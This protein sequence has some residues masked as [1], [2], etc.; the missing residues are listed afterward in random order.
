MWQWKHLVEHGVEVA[1]NV[2]DSVVV[3]HIFARSR[4]YVGSPSLIAID[5]DR[6]LVSHDIF[7]P[8]ST[9]NVSEVF[10]SN[11]RGTSWMHVSEIEGQWWSTLFMHDDAIYL[12]G[13][14]REWGYTVIR[15]SDD[16]GRTWTTPD[17]PERGLLLAGARYHCAP[18]PIIHYR[19]RLWR[20][21]EDAGPEWRDFRAFMMSASDESNLLRADSW[22]SSNRLRQDKRLLDGHLDEWAE[23][24]AVVDPDG[25]V[26]D[27]L[28]T[29]T[30]GLPEEIA[31][32]VHT[33]DD[34]LKARFDPESDFIHMPGGGKKFTI[35]W[36]P[37]SGRYWALTNY[38]PD[39]TRTA[40]GIKARNSL[41][42]VSSPDL[43]QWRVD[44]VVL[45]HPDD[46]LHAFQY[47]DWIFDGD[48]IV[49]ASRTAADDEEGGAHNYHDANYLTHHR[50]SSFRSV[51]GE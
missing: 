50:L 42:L 45:H 14:S 37:V 4:C 39:P 29:F 32:I 24:N 35:R 5:R 31:A 17:S 7:G 16:D 30:T 25:H 10:L 28:R 3:D 36:D 21:M 51:G 27:V 8:G 23:G 15:R 2:T 19:G 47:V 1:D 40:R 13:T 38:V 48:D 46:E 33:S 9:W 11:D 34:G 12:M 41:C 43:R 20:A 44:H 22:T 49:F 26:V 18:V 6:W